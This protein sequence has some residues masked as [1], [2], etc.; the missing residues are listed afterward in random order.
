MLGISSLKHEVSCTRIFV[1]AA[2]RFQ[3]HRAELPLPKRIVDPRLESAL[4]F[5]FPNLHPIFDEDDPAI[6]NIFFNYWA[7]LQKSLMLFLG[8]ETHHM[9]HPGAVI[10]ATVKN[11]DFTRYRELLNIALQIHLCFFAVRWSGQ[12]YQTKGTGTY[13]FR[14]RTNRAAFARS[15]TSFENDNDPKPLE[16]DPFL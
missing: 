14:Y 13:A 5:L 7:K 10:P 16:F 9:F 11:D 6:D 3:I 4:L 1:P 12:S 2:K 8:A 15:V